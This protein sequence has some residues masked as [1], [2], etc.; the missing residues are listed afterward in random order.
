MPSLCSATR[1]RIQDLSVPYTL[2]IPVHEHCIELNGVGARHN[3]KVGGSNPPRTH[4]RHC[5]NAV[6]F[7]F[8]ELSVLSETQARFLDNLRLP[9][10]P[11]LAAAL[12]RNDGCGRFPADGVLMEWVFDLPLAGERLSTTIRYYWTNRRKKLSCFHSGR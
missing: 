1:L 9:T 10:K 7:T 5:R 8:T 11:E 4:E 12:N 3:P 2:P 6:A